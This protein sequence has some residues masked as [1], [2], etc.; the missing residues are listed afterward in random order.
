MYVGKQLPIDTTSYIRISEFC[1]HFTSSWHT[2]WLYLHRHN[3][4]IQ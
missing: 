4:V 1:E 3:T 2:V